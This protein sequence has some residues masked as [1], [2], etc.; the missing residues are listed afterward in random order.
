MSKVNSSSF[1]PVHFPQNQWGEDDKVS[2][3]LNCVDM[4]LIHVLPLQLPLGLKGLS[5]WLSAFLSNN[6]CECFAEVALKFMEEY[7]T[8]NE[9]YLL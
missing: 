1:V 9:K 4:S 5:D 7:Q 8:K 6:L 3:K 2:V